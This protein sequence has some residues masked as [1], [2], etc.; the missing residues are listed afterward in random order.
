MRHAV[1][2]LVPILQAA[3]YSPSLAINVPGKINSRI[4]ALSSDV[5]LLRFVTSMISL[6]HVLALFN[7]DWERF[8]RQLSLEDSDIINTGVL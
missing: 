5:V 2:T 4:A 7:G 8:G 1:F 3:Y 6:A